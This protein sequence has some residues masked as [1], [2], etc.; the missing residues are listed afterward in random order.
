MG[1][2]II[3]FFFYSRFT[4]CVLFHFIFFLS[5]YILASLSFF[6]FSLSWNKAFHVY[7]FIQMA[8]SLSHLNFLFGVFG[9]CKASWMGGMCLS[10]SLHVCLYLCQD[11][12][13]RVP[14][15]YQMSVSICFWPI[16]SDS[17]LLNCCCLAVLTLAMFFLSNQSISWAQFL[18]H[19]SISFFKLCYKFDFAQFF[20]TVCLLW[21]YF[22][23]RNFLYDFR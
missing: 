14:S 2:F 4:C 12:P 10:L 8:C 11:F 21:S 20:S 9:H 18:P 1:Y 16:S 3:V 13:S 17:A 15:Q 6:L 22:I 7:T 19:F 5:F 23:R